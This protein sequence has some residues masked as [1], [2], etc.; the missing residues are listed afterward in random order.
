MAQTTSKVLGQEL[1]QLES[2][3]D[4]NADVQRR[5]DRRFVVR[6]DAQ[7][8]DVD[9]TGDAS[10]PIHIM[11]RDVSRCGFGFL[12]EQE[13]SVGSTWRLRLV[14]HRYAVGEANVIVRFTRQIKPHVQLVGCQTAM[15]SGLMLLTGVD[16][17][18]IQNG[19][20]G[21]DIVDQ[22]VAPDDVN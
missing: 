4:D 10:A 1:S 19:S 5:R 7:L 2:L 6:G 13:V 20:H 14:Q 3:R 11:L 22:F 17:T 15:D 8:V 21:G 18:D 12:C 16:P 9:R